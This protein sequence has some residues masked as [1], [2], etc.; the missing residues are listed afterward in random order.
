MRTKAISSR[1]AT[2]LQGAVDAATA[3]LDDGLTTIAGVHGA[4]ARKPFATL[5]LAPGVGDV[6]E[7]VRLVHDGITSLVYGGIRAGLTAAGAAARVAASFAPESQAHP[8]PGSVAD[9]ALAAVNG[10][11]GDRL[12]RSANPLAARMELRHRGRCVPIER[13]PLTATF[14]QAARRVVVF[15]HGL[16]CS[17]SMWRLRSQRHYGRPE[18]TYG[19]RLEA[20]LG[21]TPLYV[22]Y[23]SG[24]HIAEN[25]RQLSQLLERIVHEWPVQIDELTL[26]GHSM[27]GLVTRS[28]CHAGRAQGLRWIGPT[29]HV[30][31]LG[32]PHLGAPLEKGV[33]VVAW[34]LGWTDVTRP[35]AVA[36]NRRSAGIKDLRFGSLCDEDWQSTDLDALLSGRTSDIPLLAGANHYFVAATVTRSRLHPLG[37]AVGDLLVRERSASGR[38]R[39]RHAQFPLENGRHFAPMSHFDLL[40]HPDVYH[41]MRQWLGGARLA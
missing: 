34:C 2:R 29:R 24:L 36:L 4:I 19:S 16:A 33:N 27:G 6:S 1:E 13:E 26:I 15:V 10:F 39:T 21:Y 5:R 37:V 20:E 17:E 40:N 14:P 35:L 23:N 41:Q 25:G 12:S 18:Q 11:A 28:A 38:A 31:F 32:S 3:F 7:G 22:R 8:R 30:V 9:L